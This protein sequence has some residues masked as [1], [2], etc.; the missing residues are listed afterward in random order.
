MHYRPLAWLVFSVLFFT[1]CASS[2]RVLDE[3]NHPGWWGEL[4]K[5]T[6]LQLNEDALLSSSG[7]ALSARVEG[8]NGAPDKVSVD[9]HKADP[10]KYPEI[11]LLRKGTRIR[12]CKLQR[13][14]SSEHSQY[15]VQGEILD[16][17]QK[18]K[19][20]NVAVIGDVRT[21]GTL[22]LNANYLRVLN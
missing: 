8:S 6:V 22:R 2:S 11:R 20:T 16:G 7:L 19:L 14:V 3:T 21:K 1:S 17:D 9:R 12:C 4:G 15:R 13:I 10:Q 18:G 5:G